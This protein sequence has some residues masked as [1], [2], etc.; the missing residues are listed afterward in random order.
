MEQNDP[1]VTQL[2]T[3][4]VNAFF[5][6]THRIPPQKSAADTRSGVL[7]AL[8]QLKRKDVLWSAAVPI[9]PRVQA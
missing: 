9:L 5:M 3:E 2:V 6:G 7:L 1:S 4:M 8:I